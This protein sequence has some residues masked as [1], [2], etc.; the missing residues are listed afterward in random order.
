MRS[1]KGVDDFIELGWA[2][3][4]INEEVSELPEYKLFSLSVFEEEQCDK[5]FVGELS[6]FFGSHDFFFAEVVF[7]H[8]AVHGGV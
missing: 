6:E 7:N 4:K 5:I 2:F 8:E 3:V 1:Y